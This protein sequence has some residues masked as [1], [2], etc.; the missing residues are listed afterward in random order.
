M[1]AFNFL[2]YNTNSI[3]PFLLTKIMKGISKIR[4]NSRTREG[5]T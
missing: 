1:Y 3:I 4:F 2:L 5:A